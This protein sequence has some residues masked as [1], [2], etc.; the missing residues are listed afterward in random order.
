MDVIESK[1][2]ISIIRNT[3]NTIDTRLVDHGQRAAYIVYRMLQVMNHP[4]TDKEVRDILMACLLHDIGAYKTEEIDEMMQFESWDIYS[5]SSYGYLFFKYLSPLADYAS[6]PLFHHV[7][8]RT[9]K[10]YGLDQE[11]IIQLLSIADRVDMYML[12]QKDKTNLP[13]VLEK[14][15]KAGYFKHNCLDAFFKAEET[16]HLLDYIYAKDVDLT[17]ALF[18]E[19]PFTAKEID[20]YLHMI[21]YSIDFRSEFMVAHTITTTSISCEL[22]RLCGMNVEQQQRIYYGALLHDIGKVAIPVSILDFPGKLDTYDMEI[23]R[24]HAAYTIKILDHLLDE[25]TA[26]IASRHH[27]KLDGSGYPLGLRGEVLTK[28]ERIV[29]I[30]DILS[31]LIGKRSYKEAFDTNKIRLILETMV[32]HNQIDG[33]ITEIALDNFDRIIET[34]QKDCAP[35]LASYHAIATDYKEIITIFSESYVHKNKLMI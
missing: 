10:H 13:A 15:R 2:V 12:E 27:E 26:H 30:A 33:D 16:Y 31:A 5:H 7:H 18:E 35:I 14:C 25:E 11:D 19:L 29:A 28:S 8:Y 24:S 20:A 34:V 17:I 6:L 1:N 22:A 9:L 32:H 3:L 4:Y 23:M 21:S